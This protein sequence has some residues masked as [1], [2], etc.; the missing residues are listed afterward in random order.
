MEILGVP[1][2]LRA[3]QERLGE[4]AASLVLA[5]DGRLEPRLVADVDE[6]ERARWRALEFADRY[7][8]TTRAAMTGLTSRARARLRLVGFCGGGGRC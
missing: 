7:V 2:Y 5:G 3:L 1:R 8:A 6:A 4:G